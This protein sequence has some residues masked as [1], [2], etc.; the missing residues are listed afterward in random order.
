MYY[1]ADGAVVKQ[2]I[3][4]GK[5]LHIENF[6]AACPTKY[7]P[8]CAKQTT[9]E[10][11]AEYLRNMRRKARERNQL[12]KEQ[13]R[14]LQDENELLRQQVRDLQYRVEALTEAIRRKRDDDD[15]YI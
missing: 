15:D 13:N 10:N 12:V 2:C 1:G 8:E 7:C 3:R 6:F 14:L 9:A 11:K 5:I 4:C